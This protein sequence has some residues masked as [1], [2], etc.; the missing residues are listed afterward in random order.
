MRRNRCWCASRRRKDEFFGEASMFRGGSAILERY[1]HI[2]RR[3][4]TKMPDRFNS[5]GRNPKHAAGGQPRRRLAWAG[6]QAGGRES[7]FYF[8][9]IHRHEKM[10]NIWNTAE[11]SLRVQ[12]SEKY[13]HFLASKIWLARHR[14][15]PEGMA[16]SQFTLH[17]LLA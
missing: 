8:S 15:I 16:L 12:R 9:L 6:S 7:H 10:I 11:L 14:A 13:G 1:V 2:T 5:I 17:N 3:P 4:S